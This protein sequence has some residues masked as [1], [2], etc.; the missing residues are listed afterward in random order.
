MCQEWKTSPSCV[1][2]LQGWQHLFFALQLLGWLSVL[3]SALSLEP[4]DMTGLKQAYY[5]AN[6]WHQPEYYYSHGLEV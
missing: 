5:Q 2:W 3:T 1:W 4:N 6:D